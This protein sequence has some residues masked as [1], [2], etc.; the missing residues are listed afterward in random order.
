MKNNIKNIAVS[1]CFI[2]IIFGFMLANIILPDKEF[3]YGERRK[4]IS[5]PSFSVENLLNSIEGFI[6]P[7]PFPYC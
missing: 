6:K 3:S 1:F 7:W 2:I 4:L 5:I